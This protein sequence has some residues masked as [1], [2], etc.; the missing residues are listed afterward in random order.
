MM[1]EDRGSE[2]EGRQK[3]SE[4]R[5]SEI[6]VAQHR[7]PPSPVANPSLSFVI[8]FS[9][10]LSSLHL[11]KN[12]SRVSFL[13]TVTLSLLRLSPLHLTLKVCA[14]ATRSAPS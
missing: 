5:L 12:L 7:F 13:S 2:A 10:S 3:G 9:P 6:H 8:F 1:I 4:E 14:C 11:L